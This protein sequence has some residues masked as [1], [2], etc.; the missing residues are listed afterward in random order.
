MIRNHSNVLQ[1]NLALRLTVDRDL[2]NS[3]GLI[4]VFWCRVR[5]HG[6][7]E[8]TGQEMQYMSNGVGSHQPP[9]AFLTV[10]MGICQQNQA[11]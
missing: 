10:L 5:P 11:L 4:L 8:N 6:C 2:V 3:H 1:R 7:R 9:L